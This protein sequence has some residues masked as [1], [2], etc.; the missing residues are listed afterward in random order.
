V[1]SRL[2]G[3]LLSSSFSLKKAERIEALGFVL[4]LSL[5][6][7][8]LIQHLIRRHIK[9]RQ[10]TI[11]GWDNKQT[12]APTTLMVIHYFQHVSVFTWNQGRRRLSRPLN[13]HQKH[14]LTAIGLPESIFT[15]PVK[16]YRN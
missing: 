10:T 14:Y 13:D 8:N 5:M 2:I 1:A 7:W 4:L 15:I 9:E 3:F 16:T 6:I 11:L 12:Q